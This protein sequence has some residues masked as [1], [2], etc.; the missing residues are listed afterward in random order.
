MSLSKKYLNTNPEA[1]PFDLNEISDRLQ[2]ALPEISFALLLGSAQGGLVKA[3]SDFDLAVYLQPYKPELDFY[4]A[5]D[6]ALADLLPDVRIDTGFLNKAEPVYRFES[7]KGTLLFARDKEFY[8][9][10]FSL[11]C[12]EYESQMASY[13]RQLKYRKQ[14]K[15]AV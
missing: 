11:T 8:A 1:V 4:G 3:R 7:L 10:F 9:R 5:I 13:E 6:D 14:A 15:H 2:S 12:R